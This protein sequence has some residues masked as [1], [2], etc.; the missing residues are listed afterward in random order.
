ML[1]EREK[2]IV[3]STISDD[4]FRFIRTV[5]HTDYR[6]YVVTDLINQFD[7][8]EMYFTT[9]YRKDINYQSTKN[10]FSRPFPLYAIDH[11]IAAVP[12]SIRERK[13]HNSPGWVHK[14]IKNYMQR[15]DKAYWVS[16]IQ[17]WMENSDHV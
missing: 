1:I 15:N 11:I 4:L 5:I 16:R 13:R 9:G 10:C 17:Q 8:R 2:L 7:M 3:P 12:T 14:D 6:F